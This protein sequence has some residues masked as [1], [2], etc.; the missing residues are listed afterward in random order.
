[1]QASQQLALVVPSSSA[2]HLPAVDTQASWLR[3]SESCASASAGWKLPALVVGV[4]SESCE[5][6]S[7]VGGEVDCIFIGGMNMQV[8]S[9]ESRA[10]RYAEDETTPRY[11]G[12]SG[13]SGRTQRRGES[14]RWS[15]D[16]YCTSLKQLTQSFWA[17]R[18]PSPSGRVVDPVLLCESWT[19][20][21][22]VSR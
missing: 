13:S 11:G 4:P 9:H 2:S 20:S 17:S 7:L 8:V 21:F 5:S 1:M 15:L 19:Q 10:G 14:S 22:K 3:K 16:L 18:G 12:G 6:T